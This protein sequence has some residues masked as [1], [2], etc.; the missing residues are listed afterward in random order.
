MT[1][2]VESGGYS[3]REERFVL[4]HGFEDGHDT[5]IVG[6]GFVCNMKLWSLS[7]QII[8]ECFHV[9]VA[10]AE[11]DSLFHYQALE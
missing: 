1:Q 7:P 5:L 4:F 10:D 3:C 11:A 2:Q 6:L 8:Q 9:H